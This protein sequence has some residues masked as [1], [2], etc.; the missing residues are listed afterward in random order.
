MPAAVESMAYVGQV[1]WHGLG[2]KVKPGVSADAM[3]KAAGLDWEVATAKAKWEYTFRGKKRYR[4]SD[5]IQVLYRTDTG[6]DLS[7]VGPKYQPF[8]NHE[9]LS[10][11]QEY[12]E[13]GDAVIETVGSLNGGQHVW[14]LADLG[15][16]YD[17]GTKRNPDQVQGKVLLLNPHLY[18][19][20]AILKMTEVRVVCWNTATAALRDG[21]ESVRLWHNK[22]FNEE[23]QEEAKRRLGIAREQLKAAE[24][25]ARLLSKTG[26]EDPIAIRVAAGVMRGDP[27]NPEY[28]AQ[29][30]RTRRVL[31][32]FWGEGMGADLPSAS[33]TAWGLL[34]A[35]TQYLDHEYGRSVNNRLAYAWLGGGEAV[36]NRTRRALL[37][38]A[39]KN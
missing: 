24:K 4:T 15:V 26:L 16:G 28:E 29:N 12:V 22:E 6:E 8:Q 25:E 11:F 39:A 34:N 35:V 21:N 10:F 9:I 19:K 37:E 5:Q 3:L 36:K 17:V 13:L 20:A 1:P 33:G 14:A 23:R 38:I 30:R 31:D 32:L 2:E 18:G 7:M 27:E